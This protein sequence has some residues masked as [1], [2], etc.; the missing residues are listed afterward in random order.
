VWKKIAA[1]WNRFVGFI[2]TL[3]TAVREG[4]V[5]SPLSGRRIVALVMTAALVYLLVE[6]SRQVAS[7]ASYGPL[8]V[9][10]G[11]PAAMV[12]LLFFFTTW[13]DVAGVISA[14]KPPKDGSDD[15]SRG[16]P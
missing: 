13:G 4:G 2:R 12:L 10:L 9:L 11:V 15:L 6:E 5:D 16:G 3:S 1:V 8:L 14:L 7:M